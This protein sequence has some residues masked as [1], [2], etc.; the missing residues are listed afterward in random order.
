MARFAPHLAGRG[1][2]GPESSCFLG[3]PEAAGSERAERHGMQLTSSG[4]RLL[5]LEGRTATHPLVAFKNLL[6]TRKPCCT[7]PKVPVPAGVNL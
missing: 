4:Y 7:T 1:G 5:G 3:A 6:S 2:E